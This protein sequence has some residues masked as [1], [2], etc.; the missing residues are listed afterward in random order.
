MTEKFE[1]LHISV[2]PV[3]DEQYLVRTEQAPKGVLPAEEQVV[4]PLEE[5]LRQAATLMEDPLVGWLRASEGEV[6]SEL[7]AASGELE[8]GQIAATTQT[9]R[10]RFRSLVELGE[11]LYNALFQGSLRD[12]LTSAQ[13]IAHNRGNVLR[14]RLGLKGSR[15]PSLPW[16]VIHEDARAIA[17]GKDI[18]FSR[19]Q[20][21]LAPVALPNSSSDRVKILMVLAAPTDRENLGLKREA[22]H[23]REELKK[24]WRGST[25]VIG[26]PPEI[27]LHILEQ[28]DREELTRALE[29]NHY[30][31]LHYSGHSNV[32]PAGG[33][34]YLVSRKTGLTEVL[35]GDDLAGLLVN[36]GIRMAVFNSCRGAYSATSDPTDATG[37]RTLA[38]V[39]VKRGVPGVLAMA[40][41]ITDE[42]ALTLT[43]LF[44]YN[45]KQGYPVDLSLNRARQGLMSAYGSNQLYWALP[46]LYLH[47]EFD[48]YLT[49][50][51]A[52]A[53]TQAPTNAFPARRSHPPLAGAR[54][55]RL[56]AAHNFPSQTRN[57]P[58]GPAQWDAEVEPLHEEDLEGVY[59]DLM[60]DDF[61]D[62]EAESLV[63]DLLGSIIGPHPDAETETQTHALPQGDRTPS[64]LSATTAVG[65]LP[66]PPPSPA[67]RNSQ[68]S[69]L[70]AAESS[71]AENQSVSGNGKSW[72]VKL[73]PVAGAIGVAAIA[74]FGF[75]LWRTRSLETTRD[76]LL[77][78]PPTTL[79]APATPPEETPPVDLATLN[80][81]E[82][83]KLAFGYFN[84]GEAIAAQ[85]AV[86]E[87]LRP[88]R[89]AINFA[90]AVLSAVPDRDKSDPAISF[91][92]GRVA[93]QA[94][95]TGNPKY[96]LDDVRRYWSRAV[97][98]E[99]N[100]PVY[101]NALG[102]VYYAAGNFQKAQDAWLQSLKLLEKMPATGWKST[103]EDNS[104]G[105]STAAQPA[106]LESEEALTAYAGLALVLQKRLPE[107]PEGDR[108]AL[109]GK[110]RKQQEMVLS[111]DPLNF[112]PEA[113]G[114]NWLWPEGAI[115]DWRSLMQEQ[116]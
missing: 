95:Q 48:G 4:W 33:E 115:Q 100:S 51:P 58:P 38:E 31:V 86:E 34:L 91:L 7:S 20:P 15:L 74:L 40:E 75:G 29:Q 84:E 21:T 106:P 81:P 50:A 113:L 46:V 3:G 82:V 37:R 88:Q 69:A 10:T 112:Q 60:Y 30:Q 39:L 72:R 44:Y 62:E 54:E 104:G 2:T 98:K 108:N 36:S 45:I 28:P 5:W 27:E 49:S 9:T 111:A 16:E 103:A 6:P 73:W 102:F 52:T 85:K 56:S 105:L 114:K 92:W 11:E 87:L 94:L 61:A 26:N 32:G 55:N 78:L 17:T 18:V 57:Q 14:L 47:P 79:S 25:P 13:A 23:L 70:S 42:V 99:P 93:W 83:A 63:S 107:L 64:Q 89:G 80:T 116:N 109:L 22:L 35:T 1:E 8:S 53:A 24:R 97:Q 59:E 71:S 68:A 12:R 77:D 67:T 110:A 19:Y 66:S 43:R 41:R 76:P 101:L 96:S 65:A 90:E